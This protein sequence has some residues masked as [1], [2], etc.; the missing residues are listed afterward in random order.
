M[1]LIMI[2]GGIVSLWMTYRRRKYG[3]A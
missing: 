3:T 2:I 1:G